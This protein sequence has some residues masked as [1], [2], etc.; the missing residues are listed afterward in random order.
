M[1]NDGKGFFFFV[2][3]HIVMN[4]KNWVESRSRIKDTEQENR[5]TYTTVSI[6]CTTHFDGSSSLLVANEK[7][8]K[9]DGPNQNQVKPDQMPISFPHSQF[10]M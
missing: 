2:V 4:V 3:I 1:A 6:V 8:N 10:Q 9:N 5:Y 7:E